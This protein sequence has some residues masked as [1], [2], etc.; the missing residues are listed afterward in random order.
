MLLRVPIFYLDDHIELL[1]SVCVILL[2]VVVVVVVSEEASL[3][4]PPSSSSSSSSS[5]TTSTLF[6]L[7]FSFFCIGRFFG[8][9]IVFVTFSKTVDSILNVFSVFVDVE[10]ASVKS[11]RKVEL[12]Q[13]H[14]P[15][16][17]H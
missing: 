8:F 15:K 12:F 16:F 4:V 3:V 9:A 2:V 1:N 11:F 10:H 17:L 5:S 13:H 14:V 7:F 6:S